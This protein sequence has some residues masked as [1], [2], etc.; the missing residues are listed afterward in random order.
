VPAPRRAWSLLSGIAAILLAERVPLWWRGVNLA[1][2]C[3]A[4]ALRSA[5]VPTG[6]SAVAC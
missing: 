6:R 1:E 3:C 4:L 5:V 2:R